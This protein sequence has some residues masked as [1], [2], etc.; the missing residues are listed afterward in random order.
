MK[1]VMSRIA[2]FILAVIVITGLLFAVMNTLQETKEM[3]DE[4]RK[5][6]PGKFI[7]LKKGITHY[8]LEG[9]DTSALI[10]LI[11]GGGASGYEVFN[12]SIPFFLHSGYRVLAFDLYNRGYS[13]R[14][15]EANSPALFLSQLSELLDAL[16]INEPFN[17][18][19][20]SM[21]AVIALDYIH[22]YPDRVKQ[23]VLI[24]PAATGEFRLNTLLKIPVVSNLLMTFYWYPRTIQN[25][26]KDFVDGKVFDEYSS[27]LHYFMNFDGFKETNY[28]TWTHTLN[29]NKLPL[30]H[31]FP[32]DRVLLI[33]GQQD[34]YFLQGSEARYLSVYPSLQVKS[35][36]GA[37]HIPH[38][39]KPEEVS[40]IVIDFFGKE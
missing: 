40:N 27:R 12:E 9:P 3:T 17:M 37:G 2:L 7:K 28:S 29:Q 18:V 8:R 34:P 21:G 25:Q 14:L 22:T 19:C 5:E 15:H 16:N 30:L 11:H 33:Y 39:E 32:S 6:A 1:K 24:D 26:R 20:M 13:E 38:M 36:Q 10:I 35:I 31:T 23:L 4:V